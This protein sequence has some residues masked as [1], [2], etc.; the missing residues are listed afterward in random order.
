MILDVELHGLEILHGA[1]STLDIFRPLVYIRHLSL[2]PLQELVNALM[3]S[4]G[5][6]PISPC[7]LDILPYGAKAFSS[8]GG[9][10]PLSKD[11]DGFWLFIPDEKQQIFMTWKTRGGKFTA[12]AAATG[13]LEQDCRDP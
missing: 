10:S 5:Y 13:R 1:G 7:N 8:S 12:R 9:Y 3:V 11:W 6:S 2:Q 4:H